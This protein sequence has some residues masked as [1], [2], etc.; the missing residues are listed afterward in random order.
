MKKRSRDNLTE[1]VW[2]GS[3]S[4]P[5]SSCW[6]E[7]FIPKASRVRSGLTETQ[8]GGFGRPVR[9]FV[10]V[11]KNLGPCPGGCEPKDSDRWARG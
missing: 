5:S 7:V 4:W 6:A 2:D 9:S 8:G 11:L 1:N 10:A 3:I